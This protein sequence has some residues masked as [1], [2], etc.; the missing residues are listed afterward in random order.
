MNDVALLTEE[1]IYS[2][3]KKENQCKTKKQIKEEQMITIDMDDKSSFC[4][5][6]SDTIGKLPLL[7][8]VKGRQLQGRELKNPNIDVMFI[9]EAPGFEEIEQGEFFVGKSGRKLQEWIEEGGL[10]PKKVYLD[11]AVRC[12]LPRDLSGYDTTKKKKIIKNCQVYLFREIARVKPKVIVLLGNAA[13][14]SVLDIP[15]GILSWSGREMIHKGF[16]CYVIPTIHPAAILRNPYL[17]DKVISHFVQIKK[18]VRKKLAFRKPKWKLIQKDSEF[19]KLL[20]KLKETKK[21]V[22]DIE[23]K[24]NDPFDKSNFIIG[25]AICFEK[26]KGYFLPIYRIRKV[27]EDEKKDRKIKYEVGCDWDYNNKFLDAKK[28]KQ[29]VKVLKGKEIVG[30]NLRFDLKWLLWDGF[31]IQRFIWDTIIGNSILD[32]ELGVNGLKEISW[33]YTDFAGYEIKLDNHCKERKIKKSEYHLADPFLIAEYGCY[34]AIGTYLIKLTQDGMIKKHLFKNF[35]NESWELRYNLTQAELTGCRIDLKET[36]RL[37]DDY[38]KKRNN[39]E[40]MVRKITG[41]VNLNIKS[42][43]DLAF[44]LFGRGQILEKLNTKKTK[45]GA[46]STDASVLEDIRRKLKLKAQKNKKNAK[47]KKQLKILEAIK[48]FRKYETYISRYLLRFLKSDGRLHTNFTMSVARTARLTSKDPNLQNIPRGGELRNCIIADKGCVL[49]SIDLSQV[50]LRI[51]AELSGD[52]SMLAILNDPKGDIHSRV[53]QAAFKKPDGSDYPIKEFMEGEKRAK[54]KIVSFSTIYLKSPFTLAVDLDCSVEEAAEIINLLF[55]GFP[56]LKEYVDR[57]QSFVMQHGYVETIFG[58]KLYIPN[59]NNDNDRDREA[60]LRKAVNYPVQSGAG[61][62]LTKHTNRIERRNRK[63]KWPAQ[64]L[65]SVHDELIYNVEK[66]FKEEFI[67]KAVGEME[68]KIK[69]IKLVKLYADAKMGR[70]WGTMK[71]VKGLR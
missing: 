70:R 58:R 68:R 59:A 20:V 35:I 42:T 6:C 10:D 12:S 18:L 31:E 37:L 7:N 66:S 8:C 9:G 49:I 25:I 40:K 28:K 32:N 5:K 69:Q 38:T 26:Y 57:Q 22:L 50:E 46:I 21:V 65:L 29:L 3:E 39:L 53:G 14:W 47:I 55:E 13:M 52:K 63:E 51:A 33:M 60:A 41:R 44:A 23:T 34:D 24:G 61:D 36:Q 30:H 4:Y 48:E 1:D 62:C 16:N 54:A 19:K 71:K 56:G 11:N 27:A 45:K 64:L 17:E 15:K 2:E 43:R 67:H